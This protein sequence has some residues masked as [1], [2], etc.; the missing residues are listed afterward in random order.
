VNMLR[1]ERI[2]YYR[3]DTNIGAAPN[4]NKTFELARGDYFKWAAHDD[5]CAPTFL[6]RCVEALDNCPEVVL[7]FTRANAID[8]QGE[9]VRE[10]PA[11]KHY[12][13]TEPRTPL[14]T[15]LCFLDIPWSLSLGSC[16]AK[17]WAVH[18]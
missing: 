6:Q 5:I 2:R 12:N 18:V 15:S 4:Y 17:C 3:N 8:I 10:Y 13:A 14:S 9:I 7:A 11:R 16:G 1:D